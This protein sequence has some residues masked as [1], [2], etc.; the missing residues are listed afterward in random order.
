MSI[1]DK[2]VRRFASLPER[3]KLPK[4]FSREEKNDRKANKTTIEDL[5][6]ESDDDD[7]NETMGQGSNA[8]SQG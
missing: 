4:P 7:P 2:N 3:K 8:G 5:E 1:S 6:D